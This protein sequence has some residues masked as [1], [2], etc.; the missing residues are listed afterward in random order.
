MH[1]LLRVQFYAWLIFTHTKRCE[2]N[3]NS[4]VRFDSLKCICTTEKTVKTDRIS[5][6][7]FF[8]YF[9]HRV[10]TLQ[11]IVFRVKCILQCRIFMSFHFGYQHET[12]WKFSLSHF[13]YEYSRHCVTI[14]LHK[15]LAFVV[16]FAYIAIALQS[17]QCSFNQY[18]S[19]AIIELSVVVA[20]LFIFKLNCIAHMHSL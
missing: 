3:A 7:G 14:W 18:I 6:C 19:S 16:S 17:I 10:Q 1:F 8:F 5:R 15:F 12:F 4:F 13:R 11:F 9:R 2:S 20:R